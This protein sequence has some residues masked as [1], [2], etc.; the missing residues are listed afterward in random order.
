MQKSSSFHFFV[1]CSNLISI[2]KLTREVNCSINFFPNYVL[3]QDQTRQ[4]ITEGWDH[5]RQTIVEGRE[6]HNCTSIKK[7]ASR[8]HK[9]RNHSNQLQDVRSRL[10]ETR[11]VRYI[12]KPTKLLNIV[13]STFLVLSYI[14]KFS[15]TT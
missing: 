2:S 15:L 10:I 14:F 1:F 9:P 6:S 3:M 13:L 4:T 7:G 12:K 11:W 5:V 8:T